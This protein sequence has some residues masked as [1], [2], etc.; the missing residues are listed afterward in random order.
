M[1]N[2]D[3]EI[4]AC[5]QEAEA[6][7]KRV[8]ALKRRIEI[9]ERVH[10]TVPA[11]LT[12]TEEPVTQAAQAQQAEQPRPVPQE[13]PAQPAQAKKKYAN[14]ENAVGRNLFAVLASI[15][16]LIGVS[17]FIATIYEQIPEIVKIIA[18]YAFGGV[19]LGVGLLL[20][21]KAGNRFWLAVASCG[22]AE[23]LVSIITSH[24]YFAVLSLPAT[25]LL[26]LVWILSSFV[27]T[28]YHPTVFKTIGFVG[29]LISIGLGLSLLEPE[30][31]VM[32]LVLLGAYILL[33]VSFMIT[34][35]KYVTMNT[36]MAFGSV[37]GLMM[38]I[39]LPRHLPE[40]T[41]WL[42]SAIIIGLMALI[43]VVYLWKAKL[44]KTA[45]P[46]MCIMTL[47]VAGAFLVEQEAEISLPVSG[48]L[49]LGLWVMQ[50]FNGSQKV[51]RVV[52]SLLVG[53][54][55]L[56]MSP[57]VYPDKLLVWYAA[58][59]AVCY[60]LYW[61]TRHRDMAWMGLVFFVG[62]CWCGDYVYWVKYVLLA[63]AAVMVLLLE[64]KLL[65]K[66][67]TLQVAWYCVMFGVAYLV[68]DQIQSNF[69]NAG[70]YHLNAG[71]YHD[72][73]NVLII[74]DGVFYA[75]MAV[76]NTLFLHKTLRDPEKHLNIT[77]KS[78]PVILLQI[79]V[80]V[81]C[82]QAVDRDIWYVV[83]LGIAGSFLTLFYSLWYCVKTDWES[84]SLTVWQFVKFTLYCW[85][86]MAMLESSVILIHICLLL[87]AVGAVAVGF[88]LKQ[89]S[90]RIYGL[91][92]SLVDVVSLVLFNI[93][94]DNSL[95]LAG[96]VVLCGALCFLI[97]F[98]YSRLSKAFETEN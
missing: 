72:Y 93:E 28:K 35:K 13:R 11:A 37:A 2:R 32:Y 17:V 27:L 65:R 18:I 80:I 62:F 50:Y 41:P 55:A 94:Y 54:F 49:A 52:Y 82:L 44:H 88:W 75:L 63:V 19:L 96:G 22:L 4:R 77:A 97:S 57:F 74:S 14:L 67:D 83:A 70:Q 64:G 51:G 34:D 46:F 48:C 61:V 12:T 5:R 16:V 43:H 24:T 10:Q 81:N 92:L 84:Q 73:V 25:F 6:L 60:V 69:L 68:L 30:Q 66:D 86:V 87:V 58:F 76:V 15:L 95:Q 91:G 47:L 98:I 9:L 90:V 45:Y 56:V 3:Y 20:Y 59:A 23:L 78:L 36:A 7:D 53:V 85:L 38:F 8:Q 21:R 26:V 31:H 1:D 40:T 89:K 42:A 71:Q 29:F 33:A 39:D 79:L